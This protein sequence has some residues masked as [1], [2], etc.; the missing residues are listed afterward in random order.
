MK[1]H[2]TGGSA[3]VSI[4]TAIL[5]G[6][7][8]DGGLYVPAQ[9]PSLDW[10]RWGDHN[11]LPTLAEFAWQ[12]LAPFFADSRLNFNLAFCERVFN[13]PMPLHHLQANQYALELFHGPT[14]SFKDFGARFFAACLQGLSPQQPRTVMVATSGDT[15]SAVAAALHGLDPIQ[16]LI[17]FPWQQISLRQQK[18]ITTWG[19]NI[20]AL[21]VRGS[22]DDCQRLV[23]ASFA[24]RVWVEQ[25]H[26]TTANSINVARLLPQMIF[27]AY[28]SVYLARQNHVPINF[29]VPSGNLGNVT[30]CYWAKAMG[31]P[32]GQIQI[33][34]NAN[35]V[36]SDFWQ[37]GD[38]QP[39]PSLPT[40]ANAM[41]VGNPSNLARLRAMLGD[42]PAFQAA[43]DVAAVD[44]EQIRQ[45]IKTCYEEYQYLICPHTATAF[46]RLQSVAQQQ[47]WV[48]AA[49]AHPAK[50]EQILEPLLQ[51]RIPVP[52]SLAAMLAKP[53]QFE[54]IDADLGEIWGR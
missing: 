15:G 46:H 8:P 1:W 48:I 42:W 10:R 40:L 18:Q 3:P 21:A 54:M 45:A 51:I 23:K 25:A 35:R 24:N 12:L 5:A 20:R 29:I 13:F 37:T 39:R 53:E 44:D 34:T 41:D 11:P 17:L 7:A 43:V 4:D 36:L 6:L 50:F 32:I 22:F 49:T 38:Y 19:D 47:V 14:L 2:S 9:L 16:G 28:S 30:A 27:Y 52:A 31:F 26:L 33:A